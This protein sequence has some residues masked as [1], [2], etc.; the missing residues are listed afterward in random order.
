M[1]LMV[2]GKRWERTR[3]LSPTGEQV[4]IRCRFLATWGEGEQWARSGW[5]V[6]LSGGWHP[7]N[8]CNCLGAQVPTLRPSAHPLDE[9][10]PHILVGVHQARCLGC[11]AAR[12][13]DLVPLLG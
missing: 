9:E 1:L 3:K 12:P 8:S 10:A 13:D 2:A 4:K 7:P 5:Q 6:N 11:G